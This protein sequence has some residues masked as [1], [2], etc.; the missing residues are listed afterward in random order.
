VGAR[1]GASATEGD[2]MRDLRK[3]ETEP[4]RASDERQ[5]IERVRR[6]PPISG[7]R[8]AW[9]GQDAPRL[10]QPERLAPDAALGG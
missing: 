9:W 2:D 1:R 3:G 10:V 5:Q 4:T 6:V 8:P 7:G